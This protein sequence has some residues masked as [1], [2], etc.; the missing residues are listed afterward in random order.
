MMPTDHSDG[1]ASQPRPTRQVSV[2]YRESIVFTSIRSEILFQVL[3]VYERRR[4]APPVDLG[5]TGTYD[6]G[7]KIL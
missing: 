3:L 1:A 6:S 7:G 4:G 2:H 5:G